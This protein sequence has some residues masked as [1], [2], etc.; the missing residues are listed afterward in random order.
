MNLIENLTAFSLT[1]QEA[2][3]YMTLLSEGP[4]SGYEV[5]KISGI[6][7]SNSYTSLAS[8]VEKGAA[9]VIEESATKYIA[10]NIEEFCNNKLS[11]LNKIKEMLIKNIPQEKEEYEGYITIK[12]AKHILDKITSMILNAKERI[13][14]SAEE[15]LMY[16]LTDSLKKAVEKGL[17]VVAITDYNINIDGITLYKSKRPANQIRLIVDTTSVITGEISEGSTCL[18]SK[19]QNLVDLFRDTMKNEIKLIELGKL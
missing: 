18:Y 12:G 10:V 4:L 15:K 5:S 14:I 13:Y 16:E 17:K 7:R 2:L 1:R 9:Y 8:L 19:K 11:E 6:S 3:I